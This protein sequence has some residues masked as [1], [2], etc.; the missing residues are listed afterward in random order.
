MMICKADFQELF[1]D[2]FAANPVD[3]LHPEVDALAVGGL[4]RWQSDGGPLWPL[5]PNLVAF[6]ACW[7]RFAD[8]GSGVAG[9]GALNR[10][11]G[12]RKPWL[13]ALARAPCVLLAPRIAGAGFGYR[14][15]S[16]AR[17]PLLAACN[18]F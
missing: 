15:R 11:Q 16:F 6:G 1:R 12:C 3:G 18:P 13:T 5:A 8:I 2:L 10:L 9:G 4:A 14:A 7:D 17:H